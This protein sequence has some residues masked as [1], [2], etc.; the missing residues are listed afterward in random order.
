MVWAA[1]VH[2]PMFILPRTCYGLERGLYEK[3]HGDVRCCECR[4]LLMIDDRIQTQL[5][6]GESEK[7]DFLS[8]GIHLHLN[9]VDPRRINGGVFT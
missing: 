9:I 8:G 3:T 1:S 4:D 2:S 7:R 5:C 6:G